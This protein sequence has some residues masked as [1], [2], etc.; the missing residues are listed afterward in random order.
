VV[1]TQAQY[2]I[3]VNDA[4]HRVYV[5]KWGKQPQSRNGD[6]PWRVLGAYGSFTMAYRE[7]A[8]IA[9]ELGYILEFDIENLTHFT[10]RRRRR[11]S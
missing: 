5:G 6:S 3:Y 8:K 9:D 7:A 4:E 10:R 11:K 1:N 2:A